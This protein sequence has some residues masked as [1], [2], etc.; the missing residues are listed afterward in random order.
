MERSGDCR[1]SLSVDEEGGTVAR[2]AANEAFGVTNVGNMSD[3]GAAV[4]R[5]KHTMPVLRSEPI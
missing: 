3:I 5:R 4:M 1:H 2:V